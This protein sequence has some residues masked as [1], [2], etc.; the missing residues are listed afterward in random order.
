M[1]HDQYMV[2]SFD[3]DGTIDFANSTWAR[4]AGK[5]AAGTSLFDYVD[6]TRA[7]D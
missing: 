7:P 4:F 2:L 3:V 5:T 6:L 1:E